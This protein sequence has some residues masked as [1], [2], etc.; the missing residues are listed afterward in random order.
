MSTIKFG[1]RIPNSGPLSGVENLVTAAQEAERLGFD[2]VWVHDHVVWSSEMHRH[3]ISSG[4]AEALAEDQTADFYESLTT[5]AFLAART[6]R[7]QLGVACLVMPMRNPIYAAKQTMT[8]DHLTGGRLIVGV[9]L[10]SKATLSSN[11]F[12][13]FGVPHSA[14]GPMTDEFIDAMKAIW[15]QPLASYHGKYVDFTDAEIFPKPHQQPHPPV[16]VGGWTDH[17]AVRTGVRGDGWIPG[18]LSPAEM[19]KGAELVR[20]TAEEHGRDPDRITIAVEKLAS[21]AP[22]REEGLELALPTV[23]TS[24]TTYERD[25]DDITFATE[26]HIFGSVDDVRRRVDEFVQAGVTHFELKLMYPTMDSL[27]EQMALWAEKVFPD[28]R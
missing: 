18:W 12:D 9:G 2:S 3:H 6:Q 13:V 11:E 24:S 17:A 7:V 10:G 19:A 5:L 26:R 8:L 1:V 28:H 4:S 22:T 16:W 23:R 25:V 20:R 14:R 27:L 15:T 21:I